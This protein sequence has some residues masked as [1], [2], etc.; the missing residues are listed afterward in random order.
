MSV[1]LNIEVYHWNKESNN[2]YDYD[3]VETYIKDI[4]LKEGTLI[5]KKDNQIISVSP[6]FKYLYPDNIWSQLFNIAIHR[7]NIIVNC[8]S[9]TVNATQVNQSSQT[10]QDK[11]YIAIRH[12][13]KSDSIFHNGCKLKEG[14][15]IKLGKM[16][17][18]VK[19][20]RT[21][22]NNTIYRGKDKNF[23]EN[24]EHNN[25]RGSIDIDQNNYNSDNNLIL[26]QNRTNTHKT[27]CKNNQMCRFCL[28]EDNE[29]KNPLIAP[30]KCSGTMKFIHIDCLRNW[31]KSKVVTKTLLN[32]ISYSFKPLECELCKTH[33]P[34]R[35]H[36]KGNVFDII[37][38]TK[39]DSSYIILEQQVKDDQDKTVL[40]IMFKD[41]SGLKIGRSNDSDVRLSDISISRYHANIYD[42]KDGV[43]IDDNKSKFGSLIQWDYNF[44]LLLNKQAGFQIGRHFFTMN[45]CKTFYSTLCCQR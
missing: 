43:Y 2:L 26:R 18:E 44:K 25:I 31:L 13:F 24:E 1:E 12:T 22:S 42:R 36:I 16:I 20:I 14:S 30:C 37:E 38:M 40:L 32:M 28:C 7:D 3:S 10:N 29:E 35:F 45:M 8:C 6:G 4:H 39:P 21:N 17:L 34:N 15:V 19:E 5:L 23:Y 9:N 33:V 41:K 11:C 27:K